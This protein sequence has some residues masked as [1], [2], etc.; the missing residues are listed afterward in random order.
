[1]TFSSGTFIQGRNHETYL[2]LLLKNLLIKTLTIFF[3]IH[4]Q[5]FSK[6]AGLT[7]ISSGDIDYTSAVFLTNILQIS[8]KYTITNYF[9][10]IQLFRF[11]IATFGIQSPPNTSFK[12]SSA[13]IATCDPIMLP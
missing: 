7:L 9:V 6:S 2:L 4:L 11:K 3:H 13:T 5:T 10:S 12:K 8:E 1:M